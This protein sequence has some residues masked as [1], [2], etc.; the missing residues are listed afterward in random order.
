MI[1]K[2]LWIAIISL[3]FFAPSAQAL[4]SVAVD[5]STLNA[6]LANRLDALNNQLINAHN[7]I[8]KILHCNQTRRFY[9]QS[10]GACVSDIDGGGGG[11]TINE[12][13]EPPVCS[14]EQQLSW[15]NGAWMCLSQNAA[16]TPPTC[17]RGSQTLY[18][19]NKGWSCVTIVADNGQDGNDGDNGNNGSNGSTTVINN[20]NTNTNTNN[21]SN[22]VII[23]GSGPVVSTN[24]GSSSVISKCSMKNK[25]T[26]SCS[27]SGPASC[28]GSANNPT[29]KCDGGYRLQTVIN[30]SVSKTFLCVKN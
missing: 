15:M 20:T 4:E 13:V 27:S 2:Y 7:L 11:T 9:R 12:F 28:A 5:D 6:S 19:S 23:G 10:D 3:S 1:K 17:E 30:S 22:K 29:C 21:N 8:G 24:S 18:W 16:P 26:W 14:N 25:S